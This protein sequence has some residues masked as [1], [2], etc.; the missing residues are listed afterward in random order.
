M[1]GTLGKSSKWKAKD[2]CRVGQDS[3]EKK[4]QS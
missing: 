2:R 1:G 4:N 3:K